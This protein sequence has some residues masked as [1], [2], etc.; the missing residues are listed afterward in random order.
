MNGLSKSNFRDLLK[1]TTMGIVFYF[2]SNY[3]KQLD[4]IA[5]GSPLGPS[6]ANAF[7]C[8]H[9]KKNGFENVLLHMLLLFINVTSMT[10]FC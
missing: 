2:N 3:Y 9:E 10:L 6:L 1:L 4:G 5:M 8:H 7:L